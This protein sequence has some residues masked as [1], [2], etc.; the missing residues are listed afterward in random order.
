[1]S[2][3]SRRRQRQAGQVS[4]G[5]AGR[6][7]GTGPSPAD[8]DPSSTRPAGPGSGTRPRVSTSPTGTA[9]VGRRER[10]RIGPKPS[11]LQR[12]RGLLIGAGAIAVVALVGAALF[13]AASQP[14][15]ACSD[16]WEPSPTAEPAA[17]SSPQP[18][19]V[20][21]DMGNGHVAPGTPITFT[22]C[23]PASG[24]HYNASGQGPIQPRPYGPDDTVRPQGW[25]HNLEHG[26][27]V[28][29]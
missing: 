21:P 13:A 5:P 19:Y 18:G 7:P 2:N 8:T 15:F 24:R 10:S 11:A 16:V 26:A 20:Q 6:A 27:L 22:Y 25:V 9:R 29:L 12:Y 4:S 3:E 17:G 23:P 14:A 1:M 28:V